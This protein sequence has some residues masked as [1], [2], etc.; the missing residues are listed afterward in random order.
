[1]E[2]FYLLMVTDWCNSSENYDV[3]QI[4]FKK[5]IFLIQQYANI[6]LTQIQ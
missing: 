1:M 6:N 2:T 3:L 4:G 5:S